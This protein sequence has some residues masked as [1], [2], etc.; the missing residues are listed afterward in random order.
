MSSIRRS[1]SFICILFIAVLW[2]ATYQI[3]AQEPSSLPGWTAFTHLFDESV[4]RDKVVGSSMVVVEGGHIIAHHAHGFADI[5]NHKP[6]TEQTIFHY[7]SITKT[8]AA[9]SVMQLRDRGH[10]T[11]DDHVTQYIP[12][13]RLV[14]NPYGS[15][16][17]ITIRMLLSHSAG[18][19]G[20]TWPYKQGKPWEPFEPT[21]WA[22]LVAMMPYQEVAF[23]PGSRYSYSNPAFIYLARIVE[24]LSGDP[25]EVYVQKNIFGPL[26]LTR[27]Y[28]GVTPYYL[29]DDRSHNYNVIPD[30]SGNAIVRDNGADFDPGITIPNGGWNA[31]LTELAT[32]L[33]FLTNATHGDPV[34]EHLYDTVLKHSTFD[35]MWKP[36]YPTDPTAEAQDQSIGMSFFNLRRGQTT[37]IGHDGSQAGFLAFMYLNPANKKAVV[38]AFNTSGERYEWKKTAVYTIREE[39]LKLLE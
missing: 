1:R 11:L 29:A 5:A 12:E 14:H 26:G 9:I 2:I 15:M 8:L 17:T 22:Q 33:G 20:P 3:R 35:E 31:P 25:W 16:D 38:A 24:L 28:F 6:V 32:Y 18:F 19:Q 13:L 21:T 7:G 36:L 4:D 23:P 34:K 30:P 37:L 10:L 27:S 39:V